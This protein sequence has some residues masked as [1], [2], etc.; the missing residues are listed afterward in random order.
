MAYT[1][2]DII[3]DDEYNSFATGSTDGTGDG[4]VNGIWTTAGVLAD[5]LGYGQSP[6]LSAV[7]AGQEISATQWADLLTR[8]SFIG[9]HQG[10]AITGPWVAPIVGEI[11]DTDAPV[12]T[13][14]NAIWANR[15]NAAAQG[16]AITTGGTGTYSSSWG[17]AGQ[18][19]RLDFATQITFGSLNE[20]RHFFNC[21]GRIQ[22][23]CSRAGGTSSSKNTNWSELCTEIGQLHITGAS[24]AKTIA[25]TSFTG[26]QQTGNTGSAPIT[27]QTTLGAYL[28]GTG[29]QALFAQFDN[30]A[31][32]S[33]NWITYYARRNGAVIDV[34]L[35]FGD[36][37]DSNTDESVDGTFSYLCALIQPDTTYISNSWGTPTMSTT[38][39][40]HSP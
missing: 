29:Y 19:Q 25:G 34:I 30:S 33:A 26:F 27:Y 21:G 10:T 6:S 3:R 8:I 36:D 37:A 22:V 39:G 12:Q 24:A 32:Y 23:N 9:A 14:L 28:L 35:R 40:T 7:S 17:G 15:N 31:N 18:N 11:I 20:M 13:N 1:P 5:D 2:G 16:T 4:G 38:S